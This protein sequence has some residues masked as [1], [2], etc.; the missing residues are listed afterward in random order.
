MLTRPVIALPGLAMTFAVQE[1][2]DNVST[3]GT[4]TVAGSVLGG[5]TFSPIRTTPSSYVGNWA[6]YVGQTPPAYWKDPYGIV[7]LRGLLQNPSSTTG[8]M[9]VLP[10]S[11]R[12][13][14]YAYFAVSD[15]NTTPT[16][17]T[18]YITATTNG[19][20][21]AGSVVV[22]NSTQSVALDGVTFSTN[23]SILTVKSVY[24]LTVLYFANINVTNSAYIIV[25]ICPYLLLA[26]SHRPLRLSTCRRDE[27]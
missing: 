12:P 27:S 21:A 15:S 7:H 18:V 26:S 23:S 2:W 4:L 5:T 13:I 25:Q 6:A 14:N 20:V 10:A 11:Y 19:S 17:L 3:V 22:A 9:F 24:F 16:Y 1:L 8:A